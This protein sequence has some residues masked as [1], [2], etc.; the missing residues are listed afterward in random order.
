MNEIPM[1]DYD[2][3]A[4]RSVVGTRL[5]M[6]YESFYERFRELALRE[7][8]SITISKNPLLPDDEYGFL[9]MYC[10]DEACDCRRVMFTVASAKHHNFLAVI[11]YGW[12]SKAFYEK[13]YRRKDPD[14]IRELQ[15][16]ILNPMSEQSALA[17]ALLVLVRKTLLK[18]PAYIE[19]LKRHYRIFKETVDPEHFKHTGD[20]PGAQHTLLHN[21]RHKRKSRSQSNE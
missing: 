14:V 6:S 7:T 5:I 9:E 17:P 2:R 1:P 16:P 18:D 21:A 12:E 15:G 20:Q 11:A 13:W 8:R 4:P 3:H 19:R 10:N